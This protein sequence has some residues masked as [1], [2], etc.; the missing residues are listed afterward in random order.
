[1]F[2]AKLQSSCLSVSFKSCLFFFVF[3]LLFVFLLARSPG[4]RPFREVSWC[5]TFT[6]SVSI[7]SFLL[8][9]LSVHSR[10]SDCPLREM[11]APA[12]PLF[13]RNAWVEAFLHMQCCACP[14]LPYLFFCCFSF[15]PSFFCFN[16]S[17]LRYLIHPCT[18]FPPGLDSF[19]LSCVRHSQQKAGESH[20]AGL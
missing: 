15:H 9:L 3:G 1:M 14:S 20:Q 4:Q 6:W 10:L 7:R 16:S 8:N 19:E 11:K 17:P 13:R 12:W 18:F 2:E 5:L